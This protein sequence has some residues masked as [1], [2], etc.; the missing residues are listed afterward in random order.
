M[1]E[2]LYGID[3]NHI[4]LLL[5]G[6]YALYQSFSTDKSTMYNFIKNCRVLN[7][8][9]LRHSLKQLS[10]TR[11]VRFTI[12]YHDILIQILLQCSIVIDQE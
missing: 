4:Q 6:F 9:T 8:A 3:H 1:L 10:S 11:D 2:L 7:H 12:D 5:I